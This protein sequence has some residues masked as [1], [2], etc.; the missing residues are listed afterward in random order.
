MLTNYPPVERWDDWTEYASADWP[1]KTTRKYMLVPT[2][3]FNC[4]AACGLLAYVDK[5]DLSIRKF[6]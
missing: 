5:Q 3:C 2:I 4:E 1:R 6:E